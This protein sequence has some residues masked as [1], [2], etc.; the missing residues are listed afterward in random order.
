[1]ITHTEG[2]LTSCKFRIR[3]QEVGLQRRLKMS[4]LIMLMQEASM[5]NVIDL[6]VSLWDLEEEQ[7][8][9][10]ILRKEISIIKMPSH[11]DEV[12]VKTYPAGFDRILAY[13]DY[14]VYDMAGE[15]L[16]TASST[17]TLMNLTTRKIQRI[18]ESYLELTHDGDKLVPPASKL[19][20]HP[21]VSSSYDHVIRSGDIDWN[22]H[23]NN[24]VLSKLMLQSAPEDFIRNR[25]ISKYT[26]HIKS[27][28]LLG[29]EVRVTCA[30]LDKVTHH[31]V[32]SKSDGRLIAVAIC[33]WD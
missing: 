14:L 13:R 21:E 1:M 10:V 24:V 17:W 12:I 4:P 20:I 16:A 25:R 3:S 18:P 26:F 9:W 8:S 29:E 30:L 23:V 28:C 7:N 11:G 2:S 31:Q 15:L 6:K 22:H 27:E 19:K 32:K 33:D 5:Q